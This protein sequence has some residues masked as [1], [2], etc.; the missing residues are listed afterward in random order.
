MTTVLKFDDGQVLP[1]MKVS[2]SL[3]VPAADDDGRL[4]LV[5]VELLT[6]CGPP[7][8]VA[9]AVDAMAHHLDDLAPKLADQYNEYV[10]QSHTQGG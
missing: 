5:D 6:V 3:P 2:L 7:F 10:R 9:A 8:A 1:P 4:E